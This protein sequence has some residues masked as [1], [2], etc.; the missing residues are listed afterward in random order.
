MEEKIAFE[1]GVKHDDATRSRE[2]FQFF[3]FD[4]GTEQLNKLMSLPRI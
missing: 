4:Q 3:D 1:R 2:I